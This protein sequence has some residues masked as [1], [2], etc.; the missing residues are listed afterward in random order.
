MTGV[1]WWSGC[2]SLT[3]LFV[4][5][6]KLGLVK[7]ES[8]SVVTGCMRWLS[9]GGLNTRVMSFSYVVWFAV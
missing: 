8:L 7:Y 2:A 6:P 4:A 5:L 3:V 1:I 9:S